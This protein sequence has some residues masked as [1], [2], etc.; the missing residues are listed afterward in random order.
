MSSSAELIYW[1]T[2]PRHSVVLPA[3][4]LYFWLVSIGSWG[5][6]FVWPL[7]CSSSAAPPVLFSSPAHPLRSK[8]QAGIT[9]IA[10]RVLMVAPITLVVSSISNERE[11]RACSYKHECSPLPADPPC[12]ATTSEDTLDTWPDGTPPLQTSLP[13]TVPPSIRVDGARIPTREFTT[14]LLTA[15]DSM[16]DDLGDLMEAFV[17]QLHL[18]RISDVVD[19]RGSTNPGTAPD[20][21]SRAAGLARSLS[22][23][24]S[25]TALAERSAHLDSIRSRCGS[26]AEQIRAAPASTT[27][28]VWPIPITPRQVPPPV[29]PSPATPVDSPAPPFAVAS[30]PQAATPTRKYSLLL[31]IQQQS[32]VGPQEHTGW[33]QKRTGQGGLPLLTPRIPTVRPSF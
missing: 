13:L 28:H 6:L 18:E 12:S 8:W 27:P 23:L 19:S 33:L 20:F 32:D 16:S 2:R 5:T 24:E 4:G 17:T 9:T 26:L 31:C 25:G 7:V 21:T 14:T 29:V 22:L 11:P 10:T 30:A 15:L 3:M 1:N